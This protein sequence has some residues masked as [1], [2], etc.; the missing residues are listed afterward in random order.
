MAEGRFDVAANFLQAF[1]DS[2]PSDAD[3]LEIE[4]KYGTTAFTQLRTIPKW[5]DDPATEKKVRANVEEIVKRSK[6]AS[7]KLLRDPARV[8]KFIRNLGAT[9]EERVYAELELKRI[10]DFAIPFMVEALRGTNNKDQYAGILSAIKQIEGHT[11]AGWIAALDGLTPD[12]QF[13]V[14]TAIS[15]RP[16]VLKLQTFAQSDLAPSLWRIMALPKNQSP[17]LRALAEDLLNKML[18][19]IKADSKLPEAELVAIAPHLLR[20][21]RPLRGHQ[22]QPRRLAHDRAA[23]GVGREDR[24]SSPRSRTCPSDKP[25]STSGCGTPAGRW[26]ASPTTSRL[27]H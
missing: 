6:A 19:G 21:H 4:K 17:T 8:D 16:D 9:Y 27:R 10:G 12:Q 25:R 11:I 2:N 22:D 24:R 20:P 7:D 1:L 13:G 5:S 14:I 3:F 15:D 26:T 18:P 23:L